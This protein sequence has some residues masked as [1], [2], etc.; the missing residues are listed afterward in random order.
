MYEKYLHAYETL[1]LHHVGILLGIALILGHLIA[2]IQP[3]SSLKILSTLYSQ[4][5]LGQMLLGVG[6]G[7]FMLL[8]VKAPWNPLTI[9]LYEF[10]N[11]RNIL[12][13]ACPVTWYIMS[14]M[15]KE[16]IFARALGLFLILLAAPL[17]TSAFLKD[18]VTRI[19]IPMWCYPVLTAGMFFVA[20][21]Y[22]FRDL[23]L[24]ICKRP[25]L[26]CLASLA[27]LLYGVA[28]L[29]CAILYW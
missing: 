4:T 13:I 5:L 12:I 28:I 29:I 25:R 9:E 14:S 24:W 18:P 16:N 15:V 2:L 20:K 11:I 10:E 21:P 26:F 19:L 27:G 17:L 7:W 6:L 23:S 3:K 1:S 8:L 22:L